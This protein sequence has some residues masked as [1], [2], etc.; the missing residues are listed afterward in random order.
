MDRLSDECSASEPPHQLPGVKIPTNKNENR[1]LKAGLDE[2]DNEDIAYLN[3]RLIWCVLIFTRNFIHM[4]SNFILNNATFR[5][6]GF[7]TF[8]SL[9]FLGIAIGTMEALPHVA[10]E[11]FALNQ[12]FYTYGKFRGFCNVRLF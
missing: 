2:D 3:F 4:S 7:S 8:L 11:R 6:V 12:L 1:A 5:P 9:V 10:F